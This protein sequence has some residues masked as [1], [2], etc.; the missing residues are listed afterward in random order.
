[1]LYN[2]RYTLTTVYGKATKQNWHNFIVA[3]F[4]IGQGATDGPSGWVFISDII[5]KC[6][7]KLA[8]GCKIYDPGK[9]ENIPSDADMF[10]DN[11]TL[12]H[13]TDSFNKSAT[14]LRQQ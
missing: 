1:M 14:T 11:N 13:N 4:G 12:M 5:L 3:V 7:A 8:K 6:Y 2:L 10:V 9:E